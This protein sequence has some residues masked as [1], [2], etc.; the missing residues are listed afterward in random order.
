MFMAVDG[1]GRQ[2]PL[3][4][5][6]PVS[7]RPE[8]WAAFA[9]AVSAATAAAIP[10]LVPVRGVDATPPDPPYCLADAQV[11]WSFDRLRRESGPPAW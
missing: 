10:G 3:V 4:V 6:D 11:G 7:G 5:L 1:A 9:R 8:A 2:V